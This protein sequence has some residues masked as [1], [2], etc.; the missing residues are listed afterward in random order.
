MSIE[1]ISHNGVAFVSNEHAR[2]IATGSRTTS[3]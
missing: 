3:C 1:V 2:L